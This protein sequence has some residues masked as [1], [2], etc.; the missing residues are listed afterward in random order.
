MYK[1]FILAFTNLLHLAYSY[2]AGSPLSACNTMVPSPF[3]HHGH[4]AN[5]THS[6]PPYEIKILNALNKPVTE[7]SP[8]NKEALKSKK[9]NMISFLFICVTNCYYN[10]AKFESFVTIF[11][12]RLIVDQFSAP[13]TFAETRFYFLG[14]WYND[15]IF[16]NYSINH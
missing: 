12:K 13:L 3:E 14:D 6:D 15:Q 8:G 5:P 4:G 11:V 9:K 2:K 7:Y 16:K 10:G 1:G